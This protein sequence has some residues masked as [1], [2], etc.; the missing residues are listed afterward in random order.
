MANNPD[1]I[2]DNFKKDNNYFKDMIT[3]LFSNLP[4]FAYQCK[5]DADWSM[6]FISEGCKYVTGYLPEE[7]IDNK[8][9]SYGNIIHKNDRKNVNEKVAKSLDKKIPFETEYRIISKNGSIRWVWERGLG[10]QTQENDTVTIEGYITDITER[11]LLE[12]KTIENEKMYRSLVDLSPEG[13]IIINEK[14]IISTVNKAFCQISGFPENDFVNKYITKIPTVI[15]GDL[16]FYIKLFKAVVQKKLDENIYFKWINKSGEIRLGEGRVSII[17]INDQKYVMGLVRDITNTDEEKSELITRK[18]KAESLLHASPDI[19]FVIDRK[20]IINDYKSDI[21]ELYF[22]D[23][24]LI[25]KNIFKI[26][27]SDV[28]ETTKKYLEKTLNSHV[29]QIYTYS[30]DIPNKGI[31]H[32]EARMVKSSDNEVTAIIRDM[33][34]QINMEHNLIKAKENAEESNRLKSAFLA[35]MSHEIRTPMNAIMGFSSLLLKKVGEVERKKYIELITKSSNYLLHLI[36]DVLFYSRLQSENIPIKSSVIELDKFIKDIYDTFTISEIKEGVTLHMWLSD[37]CR[38]LSFI[39][40]REKIWETL[41]I[42]TSNAL[43]Y[44]E[45]GEVKIGCKI[46]KNRLYFYVEDTGVG[47]PE[48]DLKKV[49]DRFYRGINV[50]STSIG[51]T[52]LGLSIAKELVGLLDGKIEV[53]STLEKGTCFNF[54]IPLKTTYKSVDTVFKKTI[55]PSKLKDMIVLIAEDDA[56]NYMYLYELMKNCVKRIDHAANGKEAVIFESENKYNL[57]LMDIKMPVMNGIDAIKK[58]KAENP[59]VPIIV[60]TAYAQPEEKDEIMNAGADGYLV[61]PIDQNELLKIIS[62]ICHVELC[63]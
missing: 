31:S 16:N 50:Q 8:L 56:Y 38:Q 34:E 63:H 52:G 30:L 48:S 17:K 60:Q 9:I 61:K 3:R 21:S 42:L 35:N 15:K 18:L 39:G 6:Q 43:K 13:I 11:K 24:D 22:Q 12:L 5:M 44:T 45:K 51:G 4:G 36:N 46:K 40:D 59:D 26:L 19:M 54:Y 28:A 29:M 57:I 7:L 14:G 20:G 10:V 53:W 37:E 58:I 23:E 55:L 33:T 41:T 25:N 27:P 62:S 47:I 2:S 1:I 49:Y 32:Y